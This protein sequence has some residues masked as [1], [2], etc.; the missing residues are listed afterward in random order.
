MNILS[1][2]RT[3]SARTRLLGLFTQSYR[4]QGEEFSLLWFELSG[5]IF[6]LLLFLWQ[7]H[8]YAQRTSKVFLLLKGY[9]RKKVELNLI[10]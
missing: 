5:L 7:Y 4:G 9:N 10:T 3:C 8:P 2:L 1:R 6:L